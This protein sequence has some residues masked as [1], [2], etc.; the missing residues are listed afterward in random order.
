MEKSLN[1]KRKSKNKNKKLVNK[2]LG[3]VLG[4]LWDQSPPK[5]PTQ[6]KKFDQ[7]SKVEN[8]ARFG[9]SRL[10]SAVWFN[11]QPE[12]RCFCYVAGLIIKHD[13]AS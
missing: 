3:A 7:N 11:F 12:I 8:K 10:V 4:A 9:F 5:Y 6:T 13:T 2:N 1:K